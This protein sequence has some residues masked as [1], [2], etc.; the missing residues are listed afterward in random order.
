MLH[1]CP[2]ISS[3]WNDFHL[4]KSIQRAIQYHL[5]FSGA[6]PHHCPLTLPFLSTHCHLACYTTGTHVSFSY[7][8]YSQTYFLHLYPITPTTMQASLKVQYRPVISLHSH[9]YVVN[10]LFDKDLFK[11]KSKRGKKRR[12]SSRYTKLR[13]KIEPLLIT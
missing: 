1:L 13:I 12:V 10:M 9:K 11:E 2:N 6:L 3:A 7:T 8:V 5:L 4:I